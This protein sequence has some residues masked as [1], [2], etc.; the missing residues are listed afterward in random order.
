MSVVPPAENGTTIRTGLPG[1]CAAAENEA[2]AADSTSKQQR[3]FITGGPQERT[4]PAIIPLCKLRRMLRALA[5][6]AACAFALEAGAQAFPAKPL[7]LVVGYPPGGSGDFLTRLIADEMS[8]DLGTVVIVDNRPGAGGNIAA[9]LVARASADGYTVLNG[10]NHAINRTLYRSLPY[11][12]KD[13]VPV[14][15]IATGPTVIVVNNSSPVTSLQE[16]IAFARAN[17]GKLFNAGAGYGSA[18]HLA[19]VLF[20]SVAGVKFTSVQ[21]KGGGPAAQSL[22]AGDTQVMFA[23]SPTVMG[24]VRSGRLRALAVSMRDGSPAVPG[25]P[26]SAQ[27]GL[28][29]YNYTFWFGL[30]V[31][32]GTPAPIV[33]RLYAAAVKGLGKQEVKEKIAAQGMDATPS[34]SPEAFEADIKAEAPLLERV[35]RDSGAKVE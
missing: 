11:D 26:G 12:D 6:L 4:L 28:P 7:R 18:P 10:N 21:F 5:F 34:A 15:K 9:E 17:P 14:T 16:L 13:F 35:V 19:A 3:R 33:R 8:K 1:Y 31:P 30:Y 2:S 20:E 22:L 23:T 24:F 32:A 25:I 29:A 27:A